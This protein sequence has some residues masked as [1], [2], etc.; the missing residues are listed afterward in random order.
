VSWQADSDETP[1]E[2]RPELLSDESAAAA[3][4]TA[5]RGKLEPARKACETW[6]PAE[7]L[8]VLSGAAS[9]IATVDVTTSGIPQL[10]SQQQGTPLCTPIMTG[11][12]EVE[13]EVKGTARVPGGGHWSRQD[14]H[15]SRGVFKEVI[16]KWLSRGSVYVCTYVC[17]CVCVWCVKL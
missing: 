10:T 2:Q 16:Q 5:D 7:A 14:D 15:S 1:L 12:G 9:S 17:V 6:V 11:R 4:A 8:H 13:G 3:T